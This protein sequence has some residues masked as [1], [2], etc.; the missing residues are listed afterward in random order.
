MF[1][2]IFICDNLLF[3]HYSISTINYYYYT[4]FFKN[5]KRKHYDFRVHK[6]IEKHRWGNH[7]CTG[8][9]RRRYIKHFINH[10]IKKCNLFYYE[11][12]IAFKWAA[13]N[14][15]HRTFEPKKH[16]WH[17]PA[18]HAGQCRTVLVQLPHR[19]FES[20]NLTPFIN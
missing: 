19:N 5:K 10:G 20:I 16:V 15:A 12:G 2:L 13:A 9:M 11:S 8:W 14:L 3:I 6:S 4:P 7:C 17:Q 18:V 1:R